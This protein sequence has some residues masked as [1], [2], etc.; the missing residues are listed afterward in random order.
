MK[1]TT[2]G[3]SMDNLSDLVRDVQISRRTILRITAIAGFSYTS[4]AGASGVVTAQNEIPEDFDP[5]LVYREVWTPDRPEFPGDARSDQSWTPDRPDISDTP[6][7]TEIWGQEIDVELQNVT[8]TP[9]T[10]SENDETHELCF[11]VSNLSTDDEPD[12]F[13]IR[14]TDSIDVDSV[15]ITESGGLSPD[16]PDAKNPIEFSVDPDAGDI[17]DQ[18]IEFEVELQLSPATQ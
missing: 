16:P 4:S 9:K 5:P 12:E 11:E 15:T 2:D 13:D 8:I 14:L 17:N 3:D 10:V 18:P 6:I 7:Y 1:R